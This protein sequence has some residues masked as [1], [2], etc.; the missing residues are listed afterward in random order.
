LKSVFLEAPFLV[1]NVLQR[2][3]RQIALTALSAS[4]IAI[5]VNL[6]TVVGK[7]VA[8]LKFISPFF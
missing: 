8:F 1:R 3:D 2:Y 7:F 4:A 6:P 5:L